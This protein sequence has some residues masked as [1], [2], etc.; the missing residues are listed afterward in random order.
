VAMADTLQGMYK[1]FDETGI[2]VSVC[3]HGLIWTI[4]DMVHSGEL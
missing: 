3:C 2:F 4:A 1:R